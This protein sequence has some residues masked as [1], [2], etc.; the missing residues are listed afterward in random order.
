M[1]LSRL[2]DASF[3]GPDPSGQLTRME[4]KPS[5]RA[6]SSAAGAHAHSTEM[7][8]TISAG[9]LFRA[10]AIMDIPCRFNRIRYRTRRMQGSANLAPD[11]IVNGMH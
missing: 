4:T 9:S 8:I 7:V 3:A 11:A 6:P 1:A 2:L 10:Q 5:A